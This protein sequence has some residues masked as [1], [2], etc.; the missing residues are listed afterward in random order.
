MYRAVFSLILLVLALDVSCAMAWWNE[1][2]E[3]RRRIAIDTSVGDVTR[4]GLQGQNILI[5]LHSGN[6]DFA[7]AKPDGGDIRFVDLDDK[8]LLKHQIVFWNQ[9]DEMALVWVRPSALSGDPAKD[10]LFLY[11][12]NSKAT[13]QDTV[14]GMTDSQQAALLHLDEIEGLPKDSTSNNNHATS[15]TGGMATPAVIGNGFTLYGGG[16][17]LILAESPS[18]T[19]TDALTFSCWIRI[20]APQ[21]NAYILHLGEMGSM[22]KKGLVVGVDGMNLF[23]RNGDGSVNLVAPVDRALTADTWQL[24]TA[25]V[26]K[27]EATLYIDGAEAARAPFPEK[28]GPFSGPVTI[29]TDNAG[30]RALAADIDEL[31]IDNVVRPPAWVAALYAIEGPSQGLTTVGMEETSKSGGAGSRQLLLMGI[32]FSNLTMDAFAIIGI[33]VFMGTFAG[34]VFIY[35]AYTLWMSDKD[36]R[37]F[38]AAYDKNKGRACGTDESAF[39]KSPLYRV[40]KQGCRE[41]REL[42][43][44][45]GHDEEKFSL[46]AVHAVMDRYFVIETKNLNSWLVALILCTSGGPFLGLLGTVWGVMNTFASMAHAGEANIMAIAPGVASAL[47]T[48]VCGLLVAIPSLMAYNYLM[49]RVK[50]LTVDL[51]VFIDEFSIT[52]DKR[53]G[54]L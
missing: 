30:N 1:D 48:T 45:E 32:I 23:L 13:G 18:L 38:L 28:P 41:M 54:D 16:E 2:W 21:V 6:F 36:T 37:A 22:E 53:Y 35:K 47:L 8:S 19:L 34:G 40:Y 7:R 12:G 44:R 4:D 3:L 14:S 20:G 33:L 24:I 51:S 5:R 50:S 39:E 10:G 27:G 17:R 49:V 26:G 43:S 46:R 11:Y 25:T 15:F 31:R 9:L 29:G 52:L 42:L